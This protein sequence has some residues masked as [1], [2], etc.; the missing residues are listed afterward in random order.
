MFLAS[1]KSMICSVTNELSAFLHV[2]IYHFPFVIVKAMAIVVVV[3]FI[4]KL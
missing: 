2:F 3:P 1:Y 4:F